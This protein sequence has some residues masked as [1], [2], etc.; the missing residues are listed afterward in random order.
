[1]NGP[2]GESFENAGVFLEI[3]PRRRLVSTDAFR[4]GWIPSGRVFMV[5]EALFEDAGG[6]RTRYVARAMH[7]DWATLEEH[8]RMGFHEGWDKS[9]T[10][11]I[12]SGPA[13]D[14]C[15]FDSGSTK[16]PSST[17]RRATRSNSR[18]ITA[19]APPRERRTR[20]RS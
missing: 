11:K 14:A 18:T 19:S 13:Q 20:A 3:E 7:W 2:N 12:S 6:E 17:K 9:V 4:P 1:M 15:S 10:T 5:A 16:P 8:E